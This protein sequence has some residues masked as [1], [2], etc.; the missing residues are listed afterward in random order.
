MKAKRRESKTT[1]SK[2]AL[3]MLGV[4]YCFVKY[5]E[6]EDL[7]QKLSDAS[8][9][10]SQTVKSLAGIKWMS[11]R[12]E[13]RAALSAKLMDISDIKL[14]TQS[15]NKASEQLVYDPRMEWIS[16]STAGR[17]QDSKRGRSKKSQK[18]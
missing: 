2:K 4:N 5:S 11:L 14:S 18:K 15:L 13:A 1:E 17:L 9:A 10:L 16:K 12:P 8:L 6:V 3:G 7:K